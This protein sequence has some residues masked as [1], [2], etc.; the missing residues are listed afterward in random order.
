MDFFFFF[1]SRQKLIGYEDPSSELVL[2]VTVEVDNDSIKM[3]FR[4]ETSPELSPDRKRTQAIVI[5]LPLQLVRSRLLLFGVEPKQQNCTADQIELIARYRILTSLEP[6]FSFVAKE[7]QILA[8][9]ATGSSIGNTPYVS[10]IV[11]TSSICSLVYILGPLT[12]P[13]GEIAQLQ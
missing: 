3:S 2:N 8:S 9:S 7:C 5:V 12:L 10:F 6:V 11:I 13:D 1:C 4:G